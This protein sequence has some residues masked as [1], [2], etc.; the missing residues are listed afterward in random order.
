MKIL[1]SE[2]D[3]RLCAGEGVMDIFRDLKERGLMRNPSFVYWCKKNL[4]EIET[5]QEDVRETYYERNR[6]CRQ[7]YAKAYYEKN[8]ERMRVKYGP[9]RKAYREKNRK[10]IRA[11]Q[12]AYGEKNSERIRVYQRAYNKRMQDTTQAMIAA[13]HNRSLEC[14]LDLTPRAQTYGLVLQTVSCAGPLEID[15]ING[16]GSRDSLSLW[17]RIVHGQRQLD[18]LRLLC[19]VHN[20]LYRAN[21]VKR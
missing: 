12:K 16:G 13:Y 15:H 20:T 21:G 8:K 10:R 3:Q 14:M 1:R 6:E 11:Y 7:A 5:T 2:I 19:W 17:R 9:Y 4:K 18:D